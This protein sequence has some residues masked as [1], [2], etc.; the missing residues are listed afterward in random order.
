MS[1]YNTDIIFQENIDQNFKNVNTLEY[2]LTSY[3]GYTVLIYVQTFV[4]DSINKIKLY[5]T[6]YRLLVQV[7]ALTTMWSI[8]EGIKISLNC[9]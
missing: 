1:V 5:L 2:F 3:P 9:I 8:Y 4:L 6:K 7:T